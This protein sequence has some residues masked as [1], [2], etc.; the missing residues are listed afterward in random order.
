[1]TL[2]IPKN[3]SLCQCY[4]S[5]PQANSFDFKGGAQVQ[6]DSSCVNGVSII[7]PIIKYGVGSFRRLIK[8]KNPHLSPAL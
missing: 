5:Q 2:L 8:K 6:T 3:S 1:M 7:N 4:S